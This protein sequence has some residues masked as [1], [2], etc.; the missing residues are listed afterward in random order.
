MT[1]SK[2]HKKIKYEWYEFLDIDTL[3]YLS[4]QLMYCSDTYAIGDIVILKYNKKWYDEFIYHVN[5][6][7]WYKHS[8]TTAHNDE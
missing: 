3:D 2:K 7:L 8:E 1:Q 5:K 6:L 4:Q